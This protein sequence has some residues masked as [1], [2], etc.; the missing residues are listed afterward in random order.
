MTSF[1]LS[2]PFHK[3][4]F[5]IQTDCTKLAKQLC[6]YYG[7]YLKE[8]TEANAD[9]SAHLIEEG[10]YTITYKNI[11]VKTPSP[12]FDVNRLVAENTSYDAEFLAL[13]GAAVGH[14]G[15]AYVFLAATTGGKPL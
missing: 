9:I 4:D 3:P 8:V 12:L 10:K 2:R 7:G 15:C 14:N 6:G 13:H 5:I 1:L 11:V